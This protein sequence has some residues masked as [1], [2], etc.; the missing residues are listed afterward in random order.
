MSDETEMTEA[1]EEDAATA[2]ASL[3]AGAQQEATPEA[4][5][6]WT[7]DRETGELRPKKS[8]GRGGHKSSPTLEE[9][10]AAKAEK[11]AEEPSEAAKAPS[12]DRAPAKPQR[13]SERRKAKAEEKASAPV[14]QYR[15]GVIA[16]GMNKL[17][18]R[19]GKLI[20]V[21]DPEIGHAVISITR[22]ESEDDV[23]VGE[24]WEELAKTNPRI[25][26][27][28]L[29]MMSGGAWGQ[30][31]MAHAPILLAIILKDGIRTRIPGHRL[32]EAFLGD[33]EDGSP[34]PFSEGMGGMN[35]EDMSQMMSFAQGLMGQM[36]QNMGREGVAP[37]TPTLDYP[38][39]EME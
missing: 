33:D 36:A 39:G 34:S 19:A 14:P 37:R 13:R 3:M 20:A 31:V 17:Y 18:A 12:A 11:D 23:T 38:P 22:K 7:K 27:F 16:K 10:K 25:R 15:A 4:P 35:P 5:Y 8:P 1:T 9:L 28:L 21:M 6:G 24:A 26:K 29:K 32:I 30:L 2:F